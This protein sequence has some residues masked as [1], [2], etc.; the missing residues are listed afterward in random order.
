MIVNEA[1]INKANIQDLEAVSIRTQTIEAKT[2]A[3][4]VAII[5]VAHVSDLTA[6]NANIEKLIAADAI[7][8]QAII[9]KANITDLTAS[10]GRIEILE[11]SV[12]DIETLVNGNLTSNNIQSLILSSDKVTVVNGF[13][14]NAMIENLD[15]S[16]INAGD[17]SVNK[18]RIKSDSGN[19]LIFDNTIQIK[20]STRVRVQIGKDAN[21]DYN[22]YVWD[23]SGKLMFDATGLKADGIKNKIIRDDMVSDNA[24]ISGNKLNISSV[25][26]SIN[27]GATTLN[28]SKVL[29]MVLHK[30]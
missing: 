27:N 6:I 17:I 19:L 2:A 7:M 30:L 4:E 29:L 21:S 9:G 3:I 1:L 11:S 28:S 23:S 16:K 26:T 22:M 18:F 24:N 13:I 5:N 25:V 14:K 8:G 10:V 12:G 20:D 15:V